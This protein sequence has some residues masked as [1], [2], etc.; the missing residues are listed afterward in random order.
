MIFKIAS[1]NELT[2][3]S[4]LFVGCSFDLDEEISNC[5]DIDVDNY[6]NIAIKYGAEIKNREIWFKENDC[7]IFLEKFIMPYIFFKNRKRI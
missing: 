6:R 5:I 4:I 3:I 1:Q 7:K 2:Y